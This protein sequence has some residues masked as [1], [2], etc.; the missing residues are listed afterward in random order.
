MWY[1]HVR[2]S[3]VIYERF[4][5]AL[6]IHPGIVASGITIGGNGLTIESLA[7]TGLATDI[8]SVVCAVGCVIYWVYNQNDPVTSCL[9][10]VEASK[11]L[12]KKRSQLHRIKKAPCWI[13]FLFCLFFS[14]PEIIS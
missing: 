7:V 13:F 8:I 1:S 2:N 11:I 14:T 9:L 12:D 5:L 3:T 6:R 4:F 10:T